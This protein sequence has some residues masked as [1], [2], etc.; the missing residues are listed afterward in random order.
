MQIKAFSALLAISALAYG[1]AQTEA[2]ADSPTESS[3]QITD[4]S[5]NSLG[6]VD[7]LPA[8]YTPTGSGIGNSNEISEG[9]GTATPGDSAV[10]IHYQ[11]TD[12][13]ALSFFDVFVE[14]SVPTSPPNATY[15]GNIQI[16]NDTDQPQSISSWSFYISPTEIPLAQ[17][18]FNDLPASSFT[19]VPPIIDN[20]PP[21]P[22]GQTESETIT[23]PEPST[24]AMLMA[25]SLL[26][27]RRR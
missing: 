12:S 19:G 21:V 13:P 6:A 25:G 2:I 17:L 16:T 27:L 8:Q 23:T 10:I 9:G 22:G 4:T 11:T 18:D 14:V 20:P 1:G 5:N 3:V 7:I 24:I 15:I 26:L